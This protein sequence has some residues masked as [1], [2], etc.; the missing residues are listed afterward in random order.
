MANKETFNKVYTEIVGGDNVNREKRKRERN[1]GQL[2]DKSSHDKM[3]E[4][5]TLPAAPN[6][7]KTGVSRQ[8]EQ[9]R[10]DYFFFFFSNA[11]RHL[12]AEDW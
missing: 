6:R 4:I 8:W 1:R 2:W 5:S 7:V 10:L 12:T 9:T 11:F 3:D